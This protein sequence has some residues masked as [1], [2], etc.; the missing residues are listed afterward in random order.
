VVRHVRMSNSGA[1]F[2]ALRDYIR[3]CVVEGQEKANEETGVREKFNKMNDI[4]AETLNASDCV[5]NRRTADVPGGRKSKWLGDLVGVTA[6]HGAL[7]VEREVPNLFKF[8]RS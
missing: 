6:E 8:K 5:G 3:Q 1:E 4:S 2:G 7:V